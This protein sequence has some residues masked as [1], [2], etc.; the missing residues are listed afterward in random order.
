M[1]HDGFLKKY[2]G[3][4]YRRSLNHSPKGEKKDL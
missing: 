4:L 1:N 2:L 3:L